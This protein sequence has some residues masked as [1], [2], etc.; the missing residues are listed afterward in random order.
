MLGG[1]GSELPQ[2][3]K[4]AHLAILGGTLRLRSGQ[5]LKPCPFTKT[6][7]VDKP[8]VYCAGRTAQYTFRLIR[9]Y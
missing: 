4:P 5:A 3:L 2:G 9:N 8:F 6:I 1:A 7:P